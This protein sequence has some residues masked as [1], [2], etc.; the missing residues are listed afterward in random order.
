MVLNSI[1]SKKKTEKIPDFEN[2]GQIRP[3]AFKCSRS[4]RMAKIQFYRI[5]YMNEDFINWLRTEGNTLK[6]PYYLWLAEKH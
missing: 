2:F 1:L 5:P 4:G 3:V 6:N